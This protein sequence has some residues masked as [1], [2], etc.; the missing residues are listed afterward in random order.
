MN[1]LIQWTIKELELLWNMVEMDIWIHYKVLFVF[2][3]TWWSSDF[4]LM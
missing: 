1:W 3:E 2:R 4:G